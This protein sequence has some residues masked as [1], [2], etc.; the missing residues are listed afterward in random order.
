MSISIAIFEEFS[1][2]LLNKSINFFQI[3]IAPMTLLSIEMA[4]KF[5]MVI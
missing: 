3:K 5:W 2:S 4:P 1:A